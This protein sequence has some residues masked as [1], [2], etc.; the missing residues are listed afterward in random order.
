M[1]IRVSSDDIQTILLDLAGEEPYSET[2]TEYRYECP[3]CHGEKIKFYISKDKG[4]Y[5]CYNCENKG[6]IVQLVMNLGGFSFREAIS[7]LEDDFSSF[8]IDYNQEDND[9]EQSLYDKVM[10]VFTPVSKV[11]TQLQAPTL[12]TNTQWLK[13]NFNNPNSFPYFAYLKKRGITLEQIYQQCIGYV[14]AG[15]FTGKDGQTLTLKQS[16][17][18]PTFDDQG[19]LIY[20]NSR[21]IEPNPFIKSINA[22]GNS[23]EYSRKD[24]VYNLNQVVQGSTII[25]CEGVFNALT[26]NLPP[27][28]IGLATFGKN[29]TD[30]QLELLKAKSSLINR[31][32][33]FL[34]SDARSVQLQLAKRMVEKGISKTK[35]YLVNNHSPQDAN[36][37]GRTSSYQLIKQAKPVTD[38]ATSLDFILE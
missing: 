32:Y 4:L 21:S 8:Q 28:W 36:D 13:D 23:H 12:P 22:P 35:L 37:L 14:I 6:N 3:F 29:V 17:I 20:W 25:L 16:I 27:Q 18:F 5:I 24:V 7:Y 10:Q 2:D 15:T 38:L 1:N 26:V 9:E 19:T 33:L 34:D 31:Y 11:P 30:K